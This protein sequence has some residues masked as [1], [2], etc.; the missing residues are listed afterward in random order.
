MYYHKRTIELQLVTYEWKALGYNYMGSIR[1]PS[2]YNVI[3]NLHKDMTRRFSNTLR[4]G[5]EDK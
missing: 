4:L 3:K 5:G 1:S 2:H